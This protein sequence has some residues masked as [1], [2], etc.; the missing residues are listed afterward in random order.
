MPSFPSGILGTVGI[1]GILGHAIT[2]MVTR[3]SKQPTRPRFNPVTPAYLSLVRALDRRRDALGL[4]HE[5]LCASSGIG[6]RHWA[7]YL[8]PDSISGRV[9]CWATLQKVIDVLYPHGFDVASKI[10]LI[11]TVR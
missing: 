3:M 5:Q 9:A 7:K 2:E 11:G 10:K 6:A 8:N 1:L 4:T